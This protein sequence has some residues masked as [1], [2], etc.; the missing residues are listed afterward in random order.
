MMEMNRCKIRLP[1]RYMGTNKDRDE[2]NE[3]R[4]AH[5]DEIPSPH[6]TGDACPKS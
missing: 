5:L 1:G 6:G 4:K 2:L 3:R